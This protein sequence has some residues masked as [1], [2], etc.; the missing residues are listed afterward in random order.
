MLA[1]SKEEDTGKFRASDARFANRSYARR[2]AEAGAMLA[3]PGGGCQFLGTA[4][5][6]QVVGEALGLSLPHSA[7]SPSVSRSGSIWP[8]IRE[9]TRELE[10]AQADNERHSD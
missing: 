3:S 6:S 10:A 4:A 5:T 2:S 1:A 9:G 8:A 7:L